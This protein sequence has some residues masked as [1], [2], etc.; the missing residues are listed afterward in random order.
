MPT[1]SLRGILG[2]FKNYCTRTFRTAIRPDVDV[3]TNDVAGGTEK[4]LEILPPGL[5]R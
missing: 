5:I 1:D 2:S 3:S 4:I